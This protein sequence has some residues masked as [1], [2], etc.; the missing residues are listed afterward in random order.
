MLRASCVNTPIDCSVFQNLHTLFR[1]MCEW[2]PKLPN[3]EWVR[4]LLWPSFQCFSTQLRLFRVRATQ[5]FVS[6][7]LFFANASQDQNLSCFTG[8]ADD[9]DSDDGGIGEKLHD[10]DD[11]DENDDDEPK[12]EVQEAA[13]SGATGGATKNK[14]KRKK[15]KKKPQAQTEDGQS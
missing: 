1:V 10:D 13:T 11:N 5:P 9:G 12:P 6:V 8:L 3:R 15:K 2:G 7:P 14:K 4:A